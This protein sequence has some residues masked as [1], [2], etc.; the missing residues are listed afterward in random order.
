[1]AA[2]VNGD[3]TVDGSGGKTSAAKADPRTLLAI[4][5]NEKDEWVRSL[6]GEI[7]QSGAPASETQIDGA[8]ELFRQEKGL[9]ERTRNTVEPLK[10][11]ATV[12]EAAPP[13]SI[14]S[15]S[16]VHGVNALAPGPVIDPHPGLTIIYGENG[17][18]KTGYA[19]ILKALAKSRT[20]DE[21]LG[22]VNI[23]GAS[24]PSAAITY[25]L[26]EEKK[27]LQWGGEHGVAPFTRMSI[28]DT[29]SVSYHVDAD[30]EYVFVPTALALFDH[31]SGAIRGVQARIED[32]VASLQSGSSVLLDRFPR[33]SSIYP[34][35]ETLGASTDLAVLK[36]K[37][38]SDPNIEDRLGALRQ[39]VAALEGDSL[40]AQLRERQ[41]EA[42]VLSQASEMVSKLLALDLAKFN[43]IS[44]KRVQ[45]SGDYETFRSELFASASLPA[46]PE[47][48]WTSFIQAG[49]AYRSHLESVGAHDADRCLYCRQSLDSSAR[50]LLSKYSTYLEDKIGADLRAA[51]AEL[52]NIAESVQSIVYQD[53]D[54]FLAEY[55]SVED[56]P[57]YFEALSSVAQARKAVFDATAGATSY[58]GDLSAAVTEP[59]AVI[60]DAEAKTA[61]LIDDLQAQAADQVTAL[62]DKKAELAELTAAAE[63]ARSWS[64]IESRVSAAKE[65]D[66]LEQ[67]KR[68]F[69]GLLRGL[70]ELAKEAS[71]Q[72][73]NENFEGLFGE[74]CHALRAPTLKIQFVG[75]EGRPQRRKT[76]SA[77][78]KPSLVLSEGEQKVLALADFLA[79]ARLAG[80]T[81][82]VVFDDPVSS[83]DHRHVREVAER[84]THLAT[85]SQVIVF[86]HDILF[87][88][89]LYWLS[90]KSEHFAYFEVTDEGGKGKVAR[91]THPASESLSAI[92]SDINSTIQAAKSQDGQARIALI[93]QGYS[94]IRAWCEVFAETDLLQGV[95]RR[96]EP[97]VRMT[98]LAKIKVEKLP[99]TIET[100]TAVFDDACR[101]TEAHS[102]AI[103]TLGVAPTLDGLE[104]DWSK[105]QE[106]RKH[107]REG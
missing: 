56:R 47:E 40:P 98:N 37:A 46:E 79:E 71:D 107:Y 96:F 105:L 87:A 39:A 14:L 29:P 60:S 66:R 38:D 57:S 26:G 73:V 59:A 58:E 104:A 6:V 1:M 80:I 18:G 7:V 82:P 53:V 22:D 85:D 49:E 12:E 84:L 63:L 93:R 16:E 92:K 103:A 70:T 3:A 28:F 100:V 55:E 33:E 64:A 69:R 61:L 34:Q 24:T 102:Q 62:K 23:E 89:T 95:S 90:E 11:D 99:E 51:E 36:S 42:R 94:R 10:T 5:A 50:D 83:L 17:T 52:R 30:L 72:L 75:R 86:T 19:R 13:L 31:L 41:R 32:R 78:H 65:A 106:A 48:T 54:A 101:F 15:L 27:K 35:I 88:T 25:T 77:D 21:I 67:L 44:A 20:D 9:D 76:L 68:S 74:E 2:D 97:N 81:A 91:G 43:D 8:Y 4:W 45:L